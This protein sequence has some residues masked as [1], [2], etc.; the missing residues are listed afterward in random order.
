MLSKLGKRGDLPAHTWLRYSTL[1]VLIAKNLLHLAAFRQITWP[2]RQWVMLGMLSQ[3]LEVRQADATEIQEMSECMSEPAAS[4]LKSCLYLSRCTGEACIETIRL[5]KGRYISSGGNGSLP[6][7]PE[8]QQD[9]YI[10]LDCT[11]IEE[12]TKPEGDNANACICKPC[13]SRCHSNHTVKYVGSES[14]VCACADVVCMNCDTN[15]KSNSKKVTAKAKEGEEGKEQATCKKGE[16][17]GEEISAKAQQDTEAKV[18]RNSS[19]RRRR[20]SA[21]E[22][23]NGCLFRQRSKLLRAQAS[24]SA[25]SVGLLASMHAR[26]SQSTAQVKIV[27]GVDHVKCDK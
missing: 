22:A 27:P 24:A 20:N 18:R 10:C 4:A 2:E 6:E 21:S 25:A 14:F 7:P 11:W 16:G 5:E 3:T 1:H 13:A 9:M 19:S 12:Q 23:K 8:L 26:K 15:S 17:E